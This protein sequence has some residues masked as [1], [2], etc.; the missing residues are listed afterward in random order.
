MS[1]LDSFMN[2][3][4]LP[5]CILREDLSLEFCSD[6]FI[7]LFGYSR[8]E[9]Y[10]GG[11]D[12]LLH[13]ETRPAFKEFS[14]TFFTNPEHFEKETAKLWTARCKDGSALTLKS[15]GRSYRDKDG[16]LYRFTILE[17]M[18]DPVL[19]QGVRQ[20]QKL[21]TL[22][23][24]A[25]GVAHEIN[26]LLQPALI[27]SEFIYS[28]IPEED[29]DS[30][31]AL[32]TVLESL[33]K[34]RDIV[35]DILVFTRNEKSQTEWLSVSKTID[36]SIT[37]LKGL[38][39]SSVELKISGLDEIENIE[40]ESRTDIALIDKNAMTQILTNVV[41]NAVHA[42]EGRGSLTIDYAKTSV[43]K[44]QAGSLDIQPGDYALM[45]ITD[46]GCGMSEDTLKHIFDPF[47]T[48]KEV[49]EGTGLGMSVVYGII[50][51]WGGAVDV[52]SEIGKGTTFSF[53]FP[54]RAAKQQAQKEAL[55]A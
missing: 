33:E 8:E 30:K 6:S 45:K 40:G 48:T 54:L 49:G 11:L 18:G 39:P 17:E 13:D 19:D 4:S 29:D 26:N 28:R 9:L 34:A 55:P 10:E 41:N 44:K 35:Q 25:S 22:G 37:F 16:K 14:Q 53:Y 43:S 38:I 12:I 31:E 47:F 20:K 2:V 32:S 36:H 5:C 21:E 51:S 7:Q 52:S 24:M 23:R 46:T 3:Y 42:M 15:R 27:F 50:T 1:L